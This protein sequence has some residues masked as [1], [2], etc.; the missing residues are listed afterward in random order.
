[1][2]TQSQDQLGDR[3][4]GRVAL[5][6]GAG[7]GIGRAAALAFARRGAAVALAGRREEPLREVARLIAGEGG[8]AEV[9]AADA[10]DEAVIAALVAGVVG[11]FGRL[12]M[13]FNNAGGFDFK[14][15][16]DSTAADFD[17]MVAINLRGPWLLIK[18]EAAAMRAGG[19]GGAI[20][21][22]TSFVAQSG[23]AN[24]S[25]YAASKGGLDAMIRPLAVELGP[26]GIRIN[27]VAPGVIK[28]DMSM[29]HGEEVLE[30]MKQKAALKRLGEPADVGD[31]AVWLCTDGA[32][33]V[34][35]QTLLAD[36]G[37]TMAM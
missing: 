21:N 3:L 36:G 24:S 7:T 28:T 5:V 35:G 29:G 34:T 27:N 12:D 19:R 30:P 32:R 10:T 1:M 11:R 37:L 16:A 31:V 17:A 23:T 25:T 2:A 9:M 18:H 4:D 14:S 26:D 8:T 22:T 20:V 13:A 15:I 33:F 6:T